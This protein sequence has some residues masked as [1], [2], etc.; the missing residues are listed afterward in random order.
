LTTL[1]IVLSILFEAVR[2]FEAVGLWHFLTGTT[3][4]PDTAFLGG[5]GRG[6]EGKAAAEFG[7]VPLFAGTFMITAIAML[8]ALPVGL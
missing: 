4:S 8:V 3:W 1:G 5:A 6:D 2:F 7:S